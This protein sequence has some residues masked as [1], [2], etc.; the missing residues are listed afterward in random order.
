MDH[1]VLLSIISNRISDEDVLWLIQAIL[2]NHRTQTPGKGMPLGNLTSQFFA[3]AYLHELDIFVKHELGAKY[4]LRYVDDF[5][6]LS[7]SRGELEEH[8]KAIARFLSD[9]LKLSLHSQKTRILSL[10]SGLTL[11]GLRV[12]YHFRLLKRSNQRRIRKRLEKF[13]AKLARGEISCERVL[14]SFAGWEGYAKTADAY[15]FRTALR[16][17]VE[18]MMTLN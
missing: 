16:Q 18:R 11:L 7:R 1:G 2:Q 4:Y 5:V 13:G 6:L 17:S 8:Q 14:S 15:S 9:R 3:N 10:C 12:F